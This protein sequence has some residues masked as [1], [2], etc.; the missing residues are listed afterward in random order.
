M[1]M[2][3]RPTLRSAA[4]AAAWCSAVTDS[5]ESSIPTTTSEELAIVQ[6]SH[7]IR[8][9][10]RRNPGDHPGRW[11]NPWPA[12]GPPGPLSA[13]VDG[14][15]AD[16]PVRVAVARAVLVV[17]AARRD[18]GQD[19]HAPGDDAERRVV[20]LERGFLRDEEELAAVGVRA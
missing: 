16:V 4:S 2:A 5:G 14:Q 9:G 10:D 17:L 3:R 18:L 19:V 6:R 8:P 11:G 7:L 12:R 13:D 15:D 20:R 1:W